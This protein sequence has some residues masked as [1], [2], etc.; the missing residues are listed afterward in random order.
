MTLRTER[1]GGGSF[2]L[3]F[4][5]NNGENSGDSIYEQ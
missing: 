5:N 4:I 1:E 3:D 2:R